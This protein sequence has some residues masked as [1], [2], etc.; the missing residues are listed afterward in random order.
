M[1]CCVP[2]GPMVLQPSQLEKLIQA[3]TRRGYNLI[4]PTVRDGAIVYDA[5]ESA[6]ELPSGWTDEQAP[7]RY[8]LNR[9]NDPALFGYAV[10]PQSWKKFLYPP[11]Q[12]LWSAH[13]ED[14]T[15]RIL[16]NE[17]QTQRPYAFLGVRACELAAIKLH[18]RVLLQ[19]K[20]I[21][22]TYN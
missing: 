10:G 3:L 11:D 6:S 5:I 2:P 8:R 9:R 19:D 21:D 1:R 13:L 16:N 7:G 17:T 15:F 20:Y 18:D 4:A 22:P 14:G 12:Q